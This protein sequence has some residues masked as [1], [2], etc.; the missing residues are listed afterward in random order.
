M[1][2][3][4]LLMIIALAVLAVA[5]LIVGV[6]NDAVNF[7]NSA[8]GS[9]AVSF[10]TIIIVA[11]IGVAIGAIFSSGL[12]EVARKGIFNPHEFM[13]DEIMVI[14][15]AVMITDV[16]LLDFFNTVGMPT[17]TTVSIVFNLLGASVAMSLIKIG[18]SNGNFSDVINYINTSKVTEIISGIL[19]SVI[20]AF[21]VGALVQWVSRSLLSYNFERKAKWVG[22]L[23][24]GIAISG[25]TYF[26]FMKGI[27]GTSFAKE[28]YEAIDGL[29][30]K[31][32]LEIHAFNIIVIS[33]VFW[34]LLSYVLTLFT[35]TNIYKVIILVGT[36][37]LA[38]AFAGNDLVNFIGVPIAAWQSYEAWSISGIAPSEFSM[39]FL[40]DKVPTPTILLVI[41]GL[42]MVAT[43][44]LSKK[45]KTV[46]ETEI[47]LSR[48]GESKERFQPNFLSRGL[49]RF[50]MES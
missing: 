45:A 44:W 47:N 20:I 11:S 34:S 1:E 18:H 4:Y 50:A 14:F 30:I 17:S 36:F 2:N 38:L 26:I 42:I 29:T 19:L 32:Y 25:I 22:A 48:E 23:F 24:G 46:T 21:T 13:F 33:F 27:G 3:L 39:G 16:L 5:D 41:S 8:I 7:L 15:M 9:K 28:S 10:K 6:S 43:L 31:E 37:A 35:K 49:V 40:S 12:M